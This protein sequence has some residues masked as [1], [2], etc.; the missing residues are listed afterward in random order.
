MCG[1]L[2]QLHSCPIGALVDSLYTS[3]ALSTLLNSVA[4]SP[5]SS[6]LTCL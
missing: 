1:P 4:S 3:A 2:A 6:Y 5:P